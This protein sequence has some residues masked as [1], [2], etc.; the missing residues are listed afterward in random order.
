MRFVLSRKGFDSSSGGVASPI[1]PD[2]EMISLPIPQADRLTFGEVSY[3]GASLGDVAASLTRG[4]IGKT[5]GVH[6]DPDLRPEARPRSAGWLPAFGQSDTA[7]RHLDLQGVREGDL[8]LFFGWFRKTQGQ[9]PE[10]TYVHGSR[11][12][13]VLFGWLQV[14]DVLRP[15]DRIPPWLQS[16]PHA[17]D[18]PLAPRP[19]N[20]Y[21]ASPALTIAGVDPGL[22]G[23]GI[24]SR[25]LPVLQL[26]DPD[27]PSRSTW[28][29]PKWFTG[30]PALTYHANP[31]RW[32][33]REGH[34]TLETVGRGQ[35]FVLDCS[36][37]SGSRDWIAELFQH[38]RAVA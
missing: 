34:A 32:A 24:F 38:A 5:T 21:V 26:T 25:Y 37:R 2:G 36:D 17:L 22:P 31:R 13:H 3:R 4:R 6:L 29:V 15:G 20:I 33:V 18:P 27:A 7:A 11:D 16:H 12:L 19:N 28:R 8:F 10:L 1:L 30:T 14:G 35:E 23:G 9:F